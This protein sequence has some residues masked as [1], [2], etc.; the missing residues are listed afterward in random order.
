MQRYT[1]YRF[2]YRWTVGWRTRAIF[3]VWQPRQKYLFSWP[4]TNSR[5]EFHTNRV[6]P[7]LPAG[8]VHFTSQKN[9]SPNQ[10]TNNQFYLIPY[11][12]CHPMTI[13]LIL[14]TILSTELFLNN[15]YCVGYTAVTLEA[16]PLLMPSYCVG[17]PTVALEAWPSSPNV[18]LL[19]WIPNRRVGSSTNRR[20]PTI[21]LD[22]QPSRW[23]LDAQS[24]L[25][26]LEFGEKSPIQIQP[27]LVKEF[28]SRIPSKLAKITEF[29]V[30]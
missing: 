6:P 10:P 3:L 7:E 21:A 11:Q 2:L 27:K 17:C 4:Q 1:S 18:Q 26:F 23:K 30:R 8:Q 12:P 25:L 16:Q 15:S 20:C 9:K 13:P 14:V 29:G 24:F 28:P 5:P 19:C 22:T